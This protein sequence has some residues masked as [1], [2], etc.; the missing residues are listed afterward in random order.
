MKLKLLTLLIYAMRLS[1]IGI[2]S[3]FFLLNLLI[4]SDIEA[5]KYASVKDIVVNIDVRNASLIQL[6]R[7]LE[8]KTKLQFTYDDNVVANKK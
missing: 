1:V 4:A 5:Q 3:Q 6:F 7:E 8:R 2:F